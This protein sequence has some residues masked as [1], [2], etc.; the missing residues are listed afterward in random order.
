MRK[1]THF[2]YVERLRDRSIKVLGVYSISTE[3]ILHQCLKCFYEW[4]VKPKDISKG[5]G[6]P[7]C[8]KID[9]AKKFSRTKP[10]YE[11]LIKNRG[12]KIIGDYKGA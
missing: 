12:V 4:K 10:E 6:C 1:L 8:M 3:K 9:L 7:E 5:S 2:E 11:E